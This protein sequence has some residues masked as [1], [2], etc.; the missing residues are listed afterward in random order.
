[1]ISDIVLPKLNFAWNKL[2]GEGIDRLSRR[3]GELEDIF[4]DKAAYAA[5]PA[6]KVVY[7]VDRKSVV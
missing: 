7:E 2:T 5:L 1:M 6:D 4:C 3:L